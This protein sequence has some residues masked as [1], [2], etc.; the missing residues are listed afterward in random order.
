MG[1]LVLAA[2]S[3][4]GAAAQDGWRVVDGGGWCDG[5]AGDRDRARFCEVREATLRPSGNVAV[6]ATPHGGID[7]RAGG[8]GELR[9]QAKVTAVA[10]D[11]DTARQIA[12]GVHIQTSGTVRAEGPRSR[13]DEWW[14]VSYRLTVPGRTGLDLRSHNGGI[15]LTGVRGRTEFTTSPSACRDASGAS[16]PPTSARGDRP[17][18]P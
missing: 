2:S 8:E 13:R 12:S 6:D 11:E 3:A 10:D 5:Q 15:S 1:A 16:S 14:T 9:I 18:G 4:A 7:V 17:S